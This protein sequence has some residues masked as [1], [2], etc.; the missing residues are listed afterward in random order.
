MAGW[1][2]H[3]IIAP[4]II[5]LVAGAL[6]LIVDGANRKLKGAIS[7][8]STLLLVVVG[9]ILVAAAD[10]PVDEKWSG[11]VST[12][13][14]GDWP[15]RFG[16]VLVLDRLSAMMVLMTSLLGLAA[17]I[18]SFARWY[19]VGINFFALFQFQ[20]MGLNGAFLTGD[21][22]NLFVFFEVMLAASYGLAM[23]GSGAPR[24][25]AGL[26]YI[27]INLAAS[28][29]FLVGVSLIYS[30]TGSLNMAD[31]ANKVASL[32]P[33]SRVLFEVGASVLG[34][35]FLVKA[36][37]WPLGFWLP[38]TYS[39]ACAPVAAMF[40]I[41]T[42]VGVYVILRLWM[43]AF[44]AGAGESA[45]FGSSWLLI[46]GMLTIGFGATAVLASQ[47]LTRLASASIVVSSGTLLAAIGLGTVDVTTGALYYLVSSTFSAGALFLLI[48]LVERGR[49]AG[50]DVLAVTME[51]FAED[52]DD[53]VFD[54]D[55]GV[56][57]PGTIA[58]LGICFISCA[59][60]IAGLPPLSGFIA[61]FALLKA[62]FSYGAV[63]TTVS[64]VFMAL[65]ILSGLAAL[66]AMTRAGMRSFWATVGRQVPHVKVIEIMPI[67]GLLF[68]CLVMTIRGG[69]V[70]GYLHETASALNLPKTYITD[71]LETPYG[72][73][74][75]DGGV[76]Q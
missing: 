1:V 51:A 20:L 61:K 62:V 26:H 21:L 75:K 52:D 44:G 73:P 57:T 71:V 53:K 27:A 17:L 9:T 48:E 36:G 37:M 76:T 18:Y 32:E 66:I 60:L 74:G 58:V 38:K 42:K 68:L 69:S 54:D 13:L 25:K 50:A 28:S 40:A 33:E 39:A 24:V 47:D 11:F 45:Y 19:S 14:L 12:Y 70:I 23:H 46:G 65:L 6:S 3:L 2:H 35:A 64:W 67:M 8:V 5:P 10:A 22:F 16:I 29:L 7:L 72:K 49:E 4:I 15:A 63:I 43:L 55:I 34:V 59:L 31:L 30:V 56:A 41:M